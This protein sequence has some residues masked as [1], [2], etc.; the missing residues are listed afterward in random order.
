MQCVPLAVG[1]DENI[2]LELGHVALR[3]K[4]LHPPAGLCN[5]HTQHDSKSKTSWPL[6]RQR[7]IVKHFGVNKTETENKT[8]WENQPVRSIGHHFVSQNDA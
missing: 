3:R 6:S 5:E 7:E 2:E 1:T 4:H 8:I